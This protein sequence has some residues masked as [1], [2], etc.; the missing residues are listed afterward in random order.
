MAVVIST[1]KTDRHNIDIDR[2]VAPIL[3]IILIL[4]QLA[5]VLIS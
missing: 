3:H 4:I 2:H 1:N 5:A